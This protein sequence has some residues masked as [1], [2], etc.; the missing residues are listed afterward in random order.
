[1]LFRFFTN[2][3]VS[4]YL[5]VP[6]VYLFVNSRLHLTVYRKLSIVVFSSCF[7]LCVGF[8]FLIVRNFLMCSF[9]FLLFIFSKAQ[10]CLVDLKK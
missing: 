10:K 2:G 5:N 1:M 9:V 4:N 8:L 6:E 3:Q 7:C